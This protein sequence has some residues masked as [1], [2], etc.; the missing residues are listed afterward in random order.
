MWLV[1]RQEA[2][3]LVTV[4]VRC[5][6]VVRGPDVAP[7]WPQ[8][9]RAWKARPVP[10][11]R[12]D[13][14]PMPQVRASVDRPVLSAIDRQGPML[15]A[16]GGHG[17]RGS[18]ALQR[19]GDGYKLN[20]RVRPV[21]SDYLPR[22]QALR[23]RARPATPVGCSELSLL[24]VALAFPARRERDGA[25]FKE[26]QGGLPGIVRA[27]RCRFGMAVS[28]SPNY[29]GQPGLMAAWVERAPGWPRR[30]ARPTIGAAGTMRVG[31]W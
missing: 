21:R 3:P 25:E 24:E 8:R 12:P 31:G 16:R 6:P 11:S 1:N 15:R 2:G 27:T 23:R 9:S 19:G 22:W 18:T 29:P 17:R 4:V 10:S 30:A 13:A 26:R 28:W 20:R 5:D 7:M 14:S